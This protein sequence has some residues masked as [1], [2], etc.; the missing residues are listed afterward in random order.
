MP[1]N[2]EVRRRPAAAFI[3]A[4]A[5]VYGLLILPW[6]GW[7]DCY[8]EFFRAFNRSIFVRDGDRRILRFEPM[9]GAPGVPLDTQITLANREQRSA[10]GS[11]PAVFLA[12][13]SRAVG[14]I[15]TAVLA[16]LI[17]ASPVPWRRRCSAFLWG[18]VAMHLYIAGFI[19]VYVWNNSDE[20]SGLWLVPLLPYWKPIVVGM[21]KIMT[22]SGVSLVVPTLLWILLVFRQS[23]LERLSPHSRRHD[24]PVAAP[25]H[26]RRFC[27][28][29]SSF[30]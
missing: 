13:T 29:R 7:H 11:A 27:D 26:K 10:Q 9:L 20:A 14:W 28:N 8:G 23:D 15:P 30:M 5:F 1:P 18:M 2:A 6:P 16:A 4:F 3:A 21:F 22:T 12:V 17:V 25:A 19:A 24:G